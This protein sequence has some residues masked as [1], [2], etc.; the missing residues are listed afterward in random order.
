VLSNGIETGKKENSKEIAIKLL[1]NGLDID[2]I[3]QS[4][5]LSI[6]EIKELQKS[7]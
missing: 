6:N 4:T 2:L 3:A 7:L 1:K 5:D